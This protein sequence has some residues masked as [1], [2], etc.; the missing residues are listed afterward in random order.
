MSKR[1][2]VR[3]LWG[4]YS[5]DHDEGWVT[6][7]GRRSKMDKEILAGLD[8]EYNPEF[9]VY[10]F[11]Q[12]NYDCLLSLEV[13]KKGCHVTMVDDRPWLYNPQKEMWRHKLDLLDYAMHVDGFDEIIYMDWD[14]IPIKPIFPD[15]WE[16]L[17][18]KSAIQANLMMYRRKKCLWRD[19]DWRKTSNGGFIYIGNR[20]ITKRLIDVWEKMPPAMKFWDEICISKL[21]DDIIGGWKGVETYWKYFEPSVCNLKKKSA[22]DE[23]AMQKDICFMHYIQSRKDLERGLRNDAYVKGRS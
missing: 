6:P 18:Q 16:R 7:S 2:F 21:T 14:C 4:D 5:K 15:L 13:E 12:Q 17:H 8:N 11:G 23:L 19:V 1:A 22:S 10:V 3:V 20:E 9:Q